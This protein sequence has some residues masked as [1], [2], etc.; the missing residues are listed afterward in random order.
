MYAVG[1]CEN[2]DSFFCTAYGI[3]IQIMAVLLNLVPNK[4]IVINK[5]YLL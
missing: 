4:Y 3:F 1:V 5:S 2:P